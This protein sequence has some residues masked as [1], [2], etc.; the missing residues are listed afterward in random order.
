MEHIV[1]DANNHEV[2]ENVSGTAGLGSRS[3]S[4]RVAFHAN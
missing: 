1:D 4:I 2:T 3:H